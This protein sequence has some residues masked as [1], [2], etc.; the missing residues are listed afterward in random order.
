MEELSKKEV[1]QC[2]C[3]KSTERFFENLLRELKE[4]KLL[5]DSVTY[6]DFQVR[7]GIPLPPQLIASKSAGAKFPFFKTVWDIC[8]NPECGCMYSV[9]TMRSE[10]TKSIE[11]PRIVLPQNLQKN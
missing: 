8:A 7:E 3:C 10:V 1:S 11:V 9:L 2:P 4:K 6:F 5:P